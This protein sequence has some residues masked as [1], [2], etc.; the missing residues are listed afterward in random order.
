MCLLL[1]SLL[2]TE[3]LVNAFVFGCFVTRCLLVSLLYLPTLS[4]VP[5]KRAKDRRRVSCSSL[6]ASCQ[7]CITFV[8]KC[9][10]TS[11]ALPFSDCFSCIEIISTALDSCVCHMTVF[12]ITKCSVSLCC[13][14]AH[15]DV[16]S[17]QPCLHAN[18]FPLSPLTSVS[19]GTMLTMSQICPPV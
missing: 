5:S 7:R 6:V 2:K 10:L 15:S 16:P 1:F 11:A 18:W 9:H 14:I 19:L 8:L 12:Y 4:P 3:Q 17:V 13:V